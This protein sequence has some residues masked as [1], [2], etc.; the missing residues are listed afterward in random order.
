[1]GKA[2]IIALFES[3]GFTDLEGHA[4]TMCNDFLALVKRAT[5][6][7]APPPGQERTPITSG[8]G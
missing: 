5:R 2:E 8:Q 1:M 6:T 3:Y 7:Y 4:L